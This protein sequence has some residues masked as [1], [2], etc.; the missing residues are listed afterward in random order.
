MFI[1]GFGFSNL[2]SILTGPVNYHEV[3]QNKLCNNFKEEILAYC[4]KNAIL[5]VNLTPKDMGLTSNPSTSLLPIPKLLMGMS[6]DVSTIKLGI[7]LL[8]IALQ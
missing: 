7:N 1:S 8:P 5:Y 6:S 4:I 3:L 2:D